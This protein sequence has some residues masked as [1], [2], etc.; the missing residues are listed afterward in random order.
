MKSLDSK[1]LYKHLKKKYSKIATFFSPN[2]SL[3][4]KDPDDIFDIAGYIQR[5][6]FN[7]KLKVGFCIVG[8]GNRIYL[9]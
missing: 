7:K 1:K 9:D 5:L 8:N 2:R 6:I 3:K 4:P